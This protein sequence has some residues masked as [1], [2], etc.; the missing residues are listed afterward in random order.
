MSNLKIEVGNIIEFI[1]Q[2]DAIVNSN[3]Q[4]MISGSGVCGLI[5]KMAGKDKLENYCKS[6]YESNMKIN[7]IRVTPGFNLN[8]DIIHVFVPKFHFSKNPIA[9]LIISYENIFIEAQSKEYSNIVSA[10]LGTGV[11]GYKH[12]DIAKYVI[13]A[14]QKFSK[15]YNV[16]FFLVVTDE[17]IKEIYNKFLD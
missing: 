3:N 8:I 2:G 15:K 13:P 7:E 6:N 16:N 4:Y 10:S 14:I 12:G 17:K 9:D 11:H 1:N 5:Y